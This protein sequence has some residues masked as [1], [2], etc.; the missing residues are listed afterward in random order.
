M[1]FDEESRGNIE[2]DPETWLQVLLAITGDKERREDL[3]RKI[4]AKTGI[5]PEKVEVIISAAIEYRAKNS[6]SN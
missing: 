5:I 2:I 6:R 4:S 1:P 3:V